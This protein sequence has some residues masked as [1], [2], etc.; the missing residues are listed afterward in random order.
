MAAVSFRRA[1]VLEG[2]TANPD[3]NKMKQLEF[4]VNRAEF[5]SAGFPYRFNVSLNVLDGDG[6]FQMR[7][8][9]ELATDVVFPAI[10]IQKNVLERCKEAAAQEQENGGD[11]F[12]RIQ[13]EVR[14]QAEDVDKDQQ[15]ITLQ[16]LSSTVLG[17]VDADG[18][19]NVSAR[20]IEDHEKK[21]K[22]RQK[23]LQKK[24]RD[25]LVNKISEEFAPGHVAADVGLCR[26][27]EEYVFAVTYET[28]A[29]PGSNRKFRLLLIQ[30][31]LLETL[32]SD[33]VFVGNTFEYAK[34]RW[35]NLKKMAALWRMTNFGEEP[36]R[37]GYVLVGKVSLVVTGERAGTRRTHGT[38]G[39]GG[40]GEDEGSFVQHRTTNQVFCFGS[41]AAA[42]AGH[43]SAPRPRPARAPRTGRGR[44]S[45]RPRSRSQ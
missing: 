2:C 32:G 26:I 36:E 24:L 9:A 15:P 35:E 8:L 11:P 13:A 39:G 25:Q 27:E 17:E 22:E 37:A 41:P 7:T 33:S 14:I 45:V 4:K 1:L 34:D 28:K 31:R 29:T 38:A 19:G 12:I 40:G 16:R 30:R 42:A 21:Q 43:P 44:R 6:N 3:D 5:H 23:E 20:E 10:Y 18:G